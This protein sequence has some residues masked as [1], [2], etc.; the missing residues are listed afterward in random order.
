MILTN[1]V[2]VHQPLNNVQS[3]I[4]RVS[5]AFLIPL[6][7]HTTSYACA[8]MDN[9]G[10]VNTVCISPTTNQAANMMLQ[11]LTTINLLSPTICIFLLTHTHTHTQSYLKNFITHAHLSSKLQAMAPICSNQF[12]LTYHLFYIIQNQN[13]SIPNCKHFK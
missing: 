5:V 1:C 10:P 13:L 8:Q 4:S 11:F 2:C 9:C 12:T 6:S 7:K 3:V